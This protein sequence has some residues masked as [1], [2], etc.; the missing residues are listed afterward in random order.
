MINDVTKKGWTKTCPYVYLHIQ[1]TNLQNFLQDL[2]LGRDCM[3]AGIWEGP[4]QFENRIMA[5]VYVRLG[6]LRVVLCRPT[7]KLV[8][9]NWRMGN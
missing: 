5:R 2:K 1:L 3:L 7:K 4:P 9:R 8:S 6:A